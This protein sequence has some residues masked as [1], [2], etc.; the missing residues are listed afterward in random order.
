M[1]RIIAEFGS[2]PAAYEWELEQWI[3]A[4]LVSGATSAKVQLFKAEHFPEAEQESKRALE[5]PRDTL[6][7]AA[8]LAHAH[9][10]EF[11]ASV[12]DE[13]AAILA[14][15]HCD[16]LKLAA[17]EQYNTELIG[18]CLREANKNNKPVY[19]SISDTSTDLYLLGESFSL[20]KHLQFFTV[21]SYPVNMLR[22]VFT[23]LK[24]AH[25]FNSRGLRW[26]W[27]SHTT[28]IFDCTLAVKLGAQV[29]EKHLALSKTDLEAGHS[30]LPH[31]FYE[32]IRR[33]NQ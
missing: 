1:T 22:A 19:R 14:A 2:S 15:Q 12:F 9:G 21:Q 18:S 10:L 20:S 28:G 6:P 32:M 27:S 26:G 5:F 16:F 3:K 4:A 29:I 13:E 23:V 30:L 31:Q 8:R 33:I 24:A 25:F 7:T 11:G 17:R